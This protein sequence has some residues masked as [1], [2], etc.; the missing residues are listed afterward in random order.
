MA[1]VHVPAETTSELLEHLLKAAKTQL[2]MLRAIGPFPD[3]DANFPGGTLSELDTYIEWIE[4]TLEDLSDQIDL[5][6]VDDP[7]GPRFK[8]RRAS[9]NAFLQFYPSDALRSLV[10]LATPLMTADKSLPLVQITEAIAKA[11]ARLDST[12]HE[13][14]EAALNGLPESVQ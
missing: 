8:I 6:Y 12:D 4:S 10:E 13:A 5:A 14:V 9:G 11:G 7:D 1:W 2:D 3:N